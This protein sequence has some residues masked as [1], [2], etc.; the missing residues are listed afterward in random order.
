MGLLQGPGREHD[1]DGASVP[2]CGV[3]ASS[4]SC[5]LQGQVLE[6]DPPQ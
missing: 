3:W 4:S 5:A 1:G 2:S 6:S